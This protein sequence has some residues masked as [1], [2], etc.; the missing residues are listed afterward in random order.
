M[1]QLL[2]PIKIVRHLKRFIVTVSGLWLILLAVP[3]YASC[4]GCLCP[5]DPCQLCSLPPMESEPPKPDE[6]EVCARIRAKVPPT[7]AQPGSNE[8]FP[9]LDRS[10]AACV[11]EGGDVIRNRR[12]SDE[13]P[14]RFYCKPPI[15][16]QR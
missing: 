6:P 9:S 13:F 2:N 15:P 3:T 1:K 11:A 16:I 7:S 8:Y 5:G 10:T 14:S 4:E 12:R